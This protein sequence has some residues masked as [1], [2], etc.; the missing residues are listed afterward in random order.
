MMM[1]CCFCIKDGNIGDQGGYQATESCFGELLPAKSGCWEGWLYMT[2]ANTW[3]DAVH[4]LRQGNCACPFPHVAL[5]GDECCLNSV[6][7]V[8]KVG[9]GSVWEEEIS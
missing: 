7:I 3:P 9:W 2:G 5:A 1:N 6:C 8:E 4:F